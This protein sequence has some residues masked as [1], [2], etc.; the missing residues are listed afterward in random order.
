MDGQMSCLGELLIQSCAHWGQG[1]VRSVGK[2]ILR[3]AR[4]N[5][6]V[7]QPV[8]VVSGAQDSG[9]SA[10]TVEINCGSRLG[11]TSWR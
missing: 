9:I 10:N 11:G 2:S 1:N 3:T 7:T 8:K 5:P 6:C 4:R